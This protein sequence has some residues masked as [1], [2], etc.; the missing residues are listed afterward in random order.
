MVGVRLLT[1]SSGNPKGHIDVI[2]CLLSRTR[3]ISRRRLTEN[4]ILDMFHT[5][6]RLTDI[7]HPTKGH[8]DATRNNL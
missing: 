6:P 5:F 2:I 4:E 7:Y 3:A 8:I 1:A